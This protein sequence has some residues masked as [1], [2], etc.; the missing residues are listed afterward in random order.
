MAAVVRV[1]AKGRRREEGCVWWE[2]RWERVMVVVV[3]GRGVC[4]VAVRVHYICWWWDRGRGARR[5]DGGSMYVERST[6]GGGERRAGRVE[7]VMEV[8]L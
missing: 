1:R 3:D 2:P 7:V 8:E 5:A 6:V 4:R